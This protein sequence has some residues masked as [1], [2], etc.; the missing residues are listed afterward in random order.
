MKVEFNIRKTLRKVL[1][2]A[3]LSRNVVL[4]GLFNFSASFHL[5]FWAGQLVFVMRS[6]S[7]AC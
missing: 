3:V 4:D 5:L 2:I 6:F 7:P 1:F